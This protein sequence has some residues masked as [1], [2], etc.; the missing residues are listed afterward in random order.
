MM[1]FSEKLIF[2]IINHEYTD[3]QKEAFISSYFKVN[4][5]VVKEKNKLRL[6]VKCWEYDYSFLFD[7]V[8]SVFHVDIDVYK[9]EK[10]NTAVYELNIYGVGVG[11]IIDLTLTSRTKFYEDKKLLMAYM[12]GMVLANFNLQIEEDCSKAKSVG[13][14][15]AFLVPDIEYAE[16]IQRVL[17]D[18][19]VNAKISEWG[20]EYQLYV[21]Q[22]EELMKVFNLLK[23]SECGISFA[24]IL[25]ERE[26]ANIINRVSICEAANLDK[27]YNAS[28]KQTLAIK[29]IQEELGF[30][31]LEEGLREVAEARLKEPDKSMSELAEELNISKSCLNH[32]I[33]KILKIS[34]ELN[35]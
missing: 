5:S 9:K 24:N 10:E 27:T 1:K 4:G 23:L 22:K 35:G 12:R 3:E 26:V 16:E 30:E 29:K 13:Y 14:H 18:N 8:K 32:R 25:K 7:T 6:Q 11:A 34:E 31:K 19:N 15:F 17:A 2:E 33:R 28:A 20:G 21:K